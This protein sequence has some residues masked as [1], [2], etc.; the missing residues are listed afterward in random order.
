MA[1]KFKNINKSI[2]YACHVQLT[3]F[4]KSSKNQIN[5]CNDC[6]YEDKT[7]INIYDAIKD[8]ILDEYD[9]FNLPFN[10]D[11]K[12]K[13]KFYY[14]YDV[15]DKAIEKYGSVKNFTDIK[16]N[17]KRPK[18]ISLNIPKIDTVNLSFKRQ[19]K[20]T[21]ALPHININF[22]IN[23]SEYNN[24]ISK[25]DNS[26][27]SFNQVCNLLNS[28]H[29]LATKTIYLNLINKQNFFYYNDYFKNV[30]LAYFLDNDN[31]PND[32]PFSLLENS[33]DILKNYKD[34]LNNYKKY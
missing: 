27:F 10:Y 20:F 8:F 14:Y 25:G 12:N 2:C 22:F 24:Y 21:S 34:I 18:I 29:F 15:F 9:L 19:S 13:I 6:I 33:F 17:K 11:K 31:N 7:L 28:Y 4:I 23:C 5:L 26:G 3:N 32:I 30:A 1:N 16:F